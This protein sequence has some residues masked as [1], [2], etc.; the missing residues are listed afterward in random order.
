MDFAGHEL[1]PCSRLTEDENVRI[2]GCHQ[3][4]LVLHSPDRR[5]FPDDIAELPRL[6]HL[7]SKVFVLQGELMPQSLDFF[8]RSSIRNR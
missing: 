5:A 8:E 3:L 7:F 6:E 2:G 4:D 1:F